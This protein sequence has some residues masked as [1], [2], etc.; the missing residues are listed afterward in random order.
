MVFDV[1]INEKAAKRCCPPRRQIEQEGQFP[2]EAMEGF[3]D[4][5]ALSIILRCFFFTG[6]GTS[7]NLTVGDYP[8]IALRSIPGSCKR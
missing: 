6:R 3:H 2:V 7:P 4:R 8:G 5:K 1:V